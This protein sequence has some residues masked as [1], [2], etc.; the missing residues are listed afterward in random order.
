MIP[1]MTKFLLM[2]PPT[3]KL[4][5]MTVLV[6]VKLLEIRALVMTVWVKLLVME[7]MPPKAHHISQMSSKTHAR[8]KAQKSRREPQD[9]KALHKKSTP[10]YA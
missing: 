2:M 5:T 7:I 3:T 6:M 9:A 10:P 4:L 8:K 1:P